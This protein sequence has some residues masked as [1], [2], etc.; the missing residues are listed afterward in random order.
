M[1]KINLQSYDPE[2]EYTEYPKVQ[3]FKKKKLMDS[4]PQMPV[5]NK[6]KKPVKRNR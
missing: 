6:H 1:T 4:E 5:K 2:S 3:K